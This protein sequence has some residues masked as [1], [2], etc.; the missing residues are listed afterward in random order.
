MRDYYH[1]AFGPAAEEIEVYWDLMEDARLA[2]VSSPDFKM[3]SANRYNLPPLFASVYTKAF[4]DRAE[5]A[6]KKAEAKAAQ[7]PDLFQKRVAFIR[8]GLDV[9]RLLMETVPLMTRLREAGGMDAEAAKLA[10]ENWDAID[11]IAKS[12]PPFAISYQGLCTA[13]CGKGYMGGMQDYFGPPSEEMLRAA[14]G[15]PV[16]YAPP[17]WKLAFQ[18]DFKRRELGK[19]WKVVKGA[20]RVENGWL[21]SAGGCIVINKN[22]PGL[23]RVEFKA[24]GTGN[25]ELS[26][27]SPFIHADSTG[28]S[29]GYLLQFGGYYN[30]RTAIQRLGKATKQTKDVLITPGKVHTIV[31]EYDG[32]SVRLTVDGKTALEMAE[33]RPLVGPGHEQ[34]GFYT[35]E[36]VI[37]ISELKVFTSK[38]VEDKKTLFEGE[39]YD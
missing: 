12:A 13:I 3:G 36:G 8:A 19:D 28:Q 27:M 34:I 26:D 2:V 18:D 29:S 6:I 33:T 7:G 38:A 9:S 16:T 11:K 39:G 35:H 20:W 4:F 31:A 24:M 1:R 30:R 17:Q 25:P 15:K 37:K 5:A 10:T 22:L 32:K 14:Q 21:T 23:H